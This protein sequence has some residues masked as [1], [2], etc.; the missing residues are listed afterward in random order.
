MTE[1][2]GGSDLGA[3]V[4]TTAIPD[5]NRWKLTGEKF[6]ASNAG[7]DVAVVAARPRGAADGVRGLALFALPRLRNDGS[8]NYH[9][10]RLKDKI[11]TRS[12]PTGEV[13][14]HDS[15][16]DLLG[17][18][19]SGIYLILEVLN[20]SRV[21]NTSRPSAPQ[22]SNSTFRPAITSSANGSVW[23]A[24]RPSTSSRQS[25]RSGSIFNSSGSRRRSPIPST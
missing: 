14:L 10:R 1:A 25:S 7:A 6:F 23:N 16:A 5:G 3:G 12:V 15:E 17:S 19:E 24:R 13:E 8:L 22:S 21:A 4:E 11:G 18:Q 9:I 20:V 2:K